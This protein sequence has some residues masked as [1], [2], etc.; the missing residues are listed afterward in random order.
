MAF[1]G[2]TIANV[3]KECKERL[4]GGRIY[5]IAQ[6]E[7]DELLLTIKV[8]AGQQYRL[9]ISADASLPLIYL[10]DKNKPSPMTAPNFCMLLRKH[11]QNARIVDITQ[12]GLERI[13]RIEVEHLNELGDVCH[14]FLVVEIMGK[15]SNIIFCDE[16]DTIIDS[17]KHIS[18]MVSSVREVL[19]G[20]QY[21]IPDT[22]AKKN[23]YHVTANDFK[24]ELTKHSMPVYKALYSSFTGISPVAAN[25]ICYRAGVEAALTTDACA[26]DQLEALYTV[27]CEM[28][29]SVAAGNF[30]PNIIYEASIP[31]EYAAIPLT[32]FCSDETFV[33]ATMSELLEHYYEEKN[34][35]TR[36]RQKS[37]DLRHVVQTALERNIKKYDLQL[38]QMHDTEK[39]DQYRIYGELL[40]TYGYSVETGAKSMEALNY[41]DNTMLKIP[42][43]PQLSAGENAK[44]YFDKYG[45]LKRTVEA[46]TTLTKETKSEIDHLQSISAA[47][48]IALQ[49]E[50]LV[51]IK[52]ELTQSGYIRRKGNVKKVKVTSKPFHYISRDGFDIYVGKNNFQNEELTFQIAVGNDWWFH[53]KGIPGSHVIVRSNGK[54]PPNTTFEDAGRLAAHYSKGIGQKK[55]E[56]D[57]TEKK[58]VKKPSGGKPGFV[59]YYTN[60]SMMI[61][62]D[63]TRINP[64]P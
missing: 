51:Q 33:Y 16:L 39:K 64:A 12:P 4:L 8:N 40:H 18:G 11:L 5:K 45:K 60:Y 14:K 1:D 15:H 34:T 36:I 47:L 9:L 10:T 62:S 53:A 48:D 23:P 41:Y 63:I 54:T 44:R 28:L 27:F 25:E 46:L 58:N 56:I 29:Q 22:Q 43:D 13:V 32:I 3:V 52:E 7:K 26:L 55:I 35:I 19:P 42:L 50:D 17:I 59:I 49:E 37:V 2:I 57:Y 24:E 38:K 30:T 20:R 61:D 6:P 21:F 31:V